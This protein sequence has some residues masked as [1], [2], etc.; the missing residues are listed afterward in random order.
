M[1]VRHRLVARAGLAG[2][3]I[4]AASAVVAAPLAAT[5]G[6]RA[7]APSITIGILD[8]L[9]GPS[10]TACGPE[11]EGM[12]LA[13]AE[14]GHIRLKGARY[15]GNVGIKLSPQ[16]DQ[17]VA[18]GGS[19]G[20]RAIADS[21]AVA[22]VGPCSS[23]VGL[24]FTGLVDQAKI[25]VV[26]STAGTPSL[27]DPE[28][29]FRGTVP[30]FFYTGRLLQVARGMGVKTMSV[31]WDQ[32]NATT[33]ALYTT[34]MKQA[35]KAVGI[36]LVSEFATTNRTVDFTPAVQQIQQKNPDAILFSVGGAATLPALTAIRNAG[37]K[38]KVFAQ[39]GSYAASVLGSGALA[40]GLV[41]STNFSAAFDYPS[42]HSFVNGF[43][44]KYHDDNPSTGAANGYDAMWRV[45]RAIHDAGP[46]RVAA[47]SVANA[48][49]MIQKAL[50]AQKGAATAEGP[51]QYLPNGDAKGPC[52]VVQVVDDKGTIKVLK[53]P[54]VRSLKGLK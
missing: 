22:Q 51:L 19:T 5:H 33:S 14:A 16:D 17:S 31:I 38:Q 23:T 7:S 6:S 43:D 52:G 21:N 11:V 39:A 30:H 44:Q 50:A 40:N 12:K 49:I 8:S 35:A 24:A 47:A 1:T 34:T 26:Y 54:T 18:A 36:E 13:V 20:F 37:L 29:A 27:V 28:F 4:L 3:T 32:G 2:A 53:I 46:A 42:T 9:T 25:P 10:V 45:L 41:I 15:M 48:R